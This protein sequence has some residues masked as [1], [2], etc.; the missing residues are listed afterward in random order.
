MTTVTTA[1]A[2]GEPT[3]VVPHH[4]PLQPHLAKQDAA[5]VDPS[6]LSALS[7]EVVRPPSRS[8]GVSCFVYLFLFVDMVALVLASGYA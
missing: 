3:V 8:R 1:D 7:P 5:T 2:D 4:Q 6:K